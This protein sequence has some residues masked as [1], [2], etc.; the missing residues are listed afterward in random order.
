MKSRSKRILR[1]LFLILP[2]IAIVYFIQYRDG[3]I[4]LIVRGDDMGF[5][6]GANIGCIK[7][8]QQGILTSVEVMVPC[9]FFLEAVDMLKENPDLDV[10]IH[11]T[12]NSEWENVKWGPITNAPSL[13]DDNGYFY[14][15]TWPDEAYPANKALGTSNWNLEEIERELRTQIELA[16]FHIPHCSHATPHM[17]FHAISPQVR[18]LVFSLIKEYNIDANLRML[19]I[20]QVS[21]FEDASTPEEMISTAVKVLENLGAGTWE[22]YDHPAVIIEGEDQAWH[23]GAED[24]AMYRDAVTKALVSKKL[25]EVIERRNIKLIGYKDLKFWH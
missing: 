7:A 19:P 13:I 10:G 17:G 22:V 21:L 24:D 18:R 16:L 14:P 1:I 6:H 4:R 3:Q 8:Y 2:V 5:S 15:M 25:Q 20:K 11:L 9:A 23:V 12:L